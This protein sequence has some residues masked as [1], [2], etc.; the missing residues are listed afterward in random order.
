MPE[1]RIVQ[2]GAI[3]QLCYNCLTQFLQLL[4]P[5]YQSY[6]LRSR[7]TLVTAEAITE[8]VPDRRHAK[9]QA[10]SRR[11]AGVAPGFKEIISPVSNLQ[12][13]HH[14]G[15]CINKLLTQ[16]RNNGSSIIVRSVPSIGSINT[17][18]NF[19]ER[20]R[21][22]QWLTASCDHKFSR[23]PYNPPVDP[24]QC[25]SCA[26][27]QSQHIRPDIAHTLPWVRHQQTQGRRPRSILYNLSIR[28][29]SPLL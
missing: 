2:A 10:G 27:S 21:L 8:L 1:P 17:I 19:P 3:R 13:T 12:R 22:R 23:K 24:S 4:S 6:T 5:L 7:D 15:F 9:P 28:N 25:L 18:T 26:R 11:R 16:R 29:K 14:H 20:S